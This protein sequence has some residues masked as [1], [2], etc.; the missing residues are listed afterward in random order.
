MLPSGC[1]RLY[2]LA[3][4][5]ERFQTLQPNSSSQLDESLLDSNRSH[6]LDEVSPMK[7]KSL[8]PLAINPG[9]P[10]SAEQTP[11]KQHTEVLESREPSDQGKV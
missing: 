4:K 1:N 2:K 6:K 5:P 7:P 8:A 3:A 11:S 10:L 9:P